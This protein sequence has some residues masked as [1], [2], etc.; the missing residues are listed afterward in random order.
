MQWILLQAFL[1]DISAPN[2]SICDVK[3]IIE[4]KCM[5]CTEPDF[6][7]AVKFDGDAKREYS[8]GFRT[9][10]TQLVPWFTL[11]EVNVLVIFLARKKLLNSLDLFLTATLFPCFC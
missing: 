11:N 5:G 4:M 10:G 9:E 1:F 6:L 2:C 7:H 8:H 3:A